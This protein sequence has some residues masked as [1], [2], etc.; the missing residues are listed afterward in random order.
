MKKISIPELTFCIPIRID[1]DYRLRNLYA[2]LNFLSSNIETK[3]MVLEADSEQR[4][5]EL[6]HIDSLEYLFIKDEN[7][8]FHRTRYINIMLSKVTTSMA[9]VWDADVIVPIKQLL[10]AYQVVHEEHASM[11]IPYDGKCWNVNDF[12]S[13][14]FRQQLSIEIF[15]SPLFTKNLLNEYNSVGGAFLVDILKYK[16]CGWENEHFI[17]WGPEDEERYKRMHILGSTPTRI[18]GDLYHLYHSRGIN[19]GNN[20]FHI[21]YTTRKEYCKI[22]SMEPHQLLAYIQTWEWL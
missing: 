3:Y 10:A 1:S 6:P 19:S 14:I 20:D 22:C 4:V 16:E 21:A 18:E 11:S 2:I 5:K 12:F 9:A 15:A 8:I 7:D 17:G 13:M